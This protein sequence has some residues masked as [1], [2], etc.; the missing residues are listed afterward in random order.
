M[1]ASHMSEPHDIAAYI[2]STSFCIDL[3]F[4]EENT[5][6][7]EENPYTVVEL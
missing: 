3:N 1:P 6:W 7:L 5:D 4:Y 2:L